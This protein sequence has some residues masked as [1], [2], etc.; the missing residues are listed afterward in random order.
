MTENFEKNVLS[1]KGYVENGG[2]IIPK[3]GLPDGLP[4]NVTLQLDRHLDVYIFAD[5]SPGDDFCRHYDDCG[6][7]PYTGDCRLLTEGDSC[8][9]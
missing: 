2:I 8:N 4:V 3:V 7:C 5:E 1:A 9:E 6:D